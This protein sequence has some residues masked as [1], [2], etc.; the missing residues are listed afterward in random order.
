MAEIK[1][2]RNDASVDEFLDGVDNEKRRDDARVALEM[3]KEVVGAEPAMW[4]TAI[5]GFEPYR[6]RPASGGAEHEWFTI[7][8]SPRKQSLT[9][10]IMDGFTEH[11]SLLEEL[12]P[13]S[14]GKSCLY[15][16]DIDKVDKGVLRRLMEASVESVRGRRQD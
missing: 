4:G 11:D 8:L 14:T 1:T 12:G 2:T 9:L 10:Y 16:K 7:G 15:I 6:Y 3:M 5:V 13:H